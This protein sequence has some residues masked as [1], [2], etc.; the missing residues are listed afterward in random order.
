MERIRC[1]INRIFP[2]SYLWLIR[3]IGLI[4]PRRLRADWR[5][6]W[7][8]ELRYRE[9][10]LAG[11]DNLN[12]KT[13]LDLFRRSLGAFWDALWL[14]PQ[15]LEDEMFQDLR[16]G[17][18][19]LL[20]HKAV[21]G[22]AALSLALGIGANTA[23]FSLVDAVLLK[24]LPVKNPEELVL[25]KWL[26]GPNRMAGTVD[27]IT[28]T[29]PET[30]LRGS[31]SFSYA[32]F[33]QFRA[34]NQTLTDI[35]AFA[36][37]QQ[38]NVNIGG[39]AEIAGGQ[40]VSGNYYAGLGVPALLGRTILDEDDRA[41]AQPVAVL[42]H[43][44]WQRRFGGD[45]AIIG[46]TI[47][48]N[49]TPCAVIGVMPPAFVGALQVGE[50]PDLSLAL[51]TEPRLRQGGSSL[52]QPWLWWVRVMGRL[53][54]GVNAEAARASLEGVFQRSAAEGWEALPP[55]RRTSQ[56]AGPRD[57]PHLRL[58]PGGQ[59]LT[60]ARA[61]YAQPL[62]ILLVVVGLALLIACA[63]VANL[64]LA[65]AEAR[66]KE[67]AVRLALGAGRARLIRQ[68][69]TE[70][71]LLA[72]LGGVG[73]LLFAWWMKDL[74]LMWHPWYASGLQLDLRLD[75]RVFGFTTAMSLLTGALFGLAPALRATRVE[76]AP[77][78][79]E[80]AGG[81]S[82]RARLSQAL[83]VAQVAM[84]LAL[85]VGAGLFARTLRNLSNV[86]VGFNRDNLLLFR[87]DPRLNNYR[88]E[89]IA[90]LYERMVTRLEAVPGVR[91]ASFARHPLL[92]GSAMRDGI[93]VQGQPS[94]GGNNGVY[95][96]R[97]HANFFATMEMSL[98]AG[99]S[100]RAQDD[101]RAPRVAV[102]N[103]AVARKFFGHDNPLGQR[104]GFGAPENNSQIEIVGV[105]SDAKYTSLRQENPATVYI[106]YTQERPTQ[107]NFAVRAAG[108]PTAL[109]ASIRAAV[110]EV[111]GNL[112]L[113]DIKTQRR[114]A[115]ESLA[116]E[117]LFARLTGFFAA[118]ALVLSAIGVYGV[119]AHTVAQRTRE[120]GIRM[121]LG[122][123]RRAVVRLV[124]AQGMGLVLVGVALGVAGALALT[125]LVASM[126]FGVRAHDPLTFGAVVLLLAGV[127]LLACY[128]P[129]RR[130]ARIDP[131]Q[132][133]RHD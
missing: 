44:Y 47:N 103:Q 125:R 99:R 35:F 16:Y 112:P 66:R 29:D 22:V 40:L 56:N 123:T 43:R 1:A 34:H 31:A 87:V 89:Q 118:L 7:E 36:P 109:V 39:Q 80:N 32:T 132:A 70:S 18:R 93:N 38:L 21:T 48:V 3:F 4:V 9:T 129:A 83:V 98:Q 82:R 20:K 42:S 67:I 111:D 58:T 8:A 90:D 46:Q 12:W 5:Q 76:L 59:G 74:L 104:F 128:A 127:A 37:V 2:R 86:E 49:N 41:G 79:K 96:M 25:F 85:L 106:P 45:A 119:L 97:V 107:M 95:V 121:A 81:A 26:S 23:L 55:Q 61:A 131:L 30:G 14:Q 52:T 78:L 100:L 24:M 133:L 130:A 6:E 53:K 68:L 64:L 50:A 88:D 33:T 115:E 126:L 13:K 105:V 113:F 71:V 110:R 10:L 114:Q 62:K 94:R 77:A 57:A 75:W 73:G 60:E 63:N 15:R 92:S 11:W 91:A 117:R 101:H 72:S 28:A 27:G 116:Q 102:I 19:M 54:P 120:I 69:L 122:A 51:A 65:R 17:V 84:S 108:D 124:V